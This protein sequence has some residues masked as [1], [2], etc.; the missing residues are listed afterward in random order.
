MIKPVETFKQMSTGQKVAT[1][2]GIA[3]GAA[4]VAT[5]AVALAKGKTDAF[6]KLSKEQT[7]AQNLGTIGGNISKVFKKAG[8]GYNEIGKEIATFWNNTIAKIKPNKIK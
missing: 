8:N 6:V 5:T 4:A 1:V 7:F 3:A 2:A